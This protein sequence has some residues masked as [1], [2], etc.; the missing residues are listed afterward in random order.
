M[1]IPSGNAFSQE[2]NLNKAEVKGSTLFKN[3]SVEKIIGIPVI[4]N[5]ENLK[6]KIEELLIYYINEGYLNVKVDTEIDTSRESIILKFKEGKNYKLK[7]ILDENFKNN[8][9]T[10]FSNTAEM[11]TVIKEMLEFLN[12]N[13]YPY[14]SIVIDSILVNDHK[15][16]FFIKLD[17]G[18]EVRI[19]T[20]I[21][22]GV[23]NTNRDLIIKESGLKEGMLFN[24][25][26]YDKA[27]QYLNNSGYLEVKNIR[28][29]VGLSSGKYGS[30]LDLKEKKGNRFNGIIGYM[31]SRTVAE[32][33][34]FV[35]EFNL[36]LSNISGTGR[37]FGIRWNKP[38]KN[39]QEVRLAY[40]E[41]WIL[42]L[43]FNLNLHFN[44]AFYDS[45]Y[46]KRRIGITLNTR[47]GDKITGNV[48]IGSENVIPHEKNTTLIKYSGLAVSAEL[49]YNSMDYMLNP[50]DGILFGNSVEYVQRE[51]ENNSDNILD[52]R[53]FVNFEFARALFKN[54]VFYLKIF[55]SRISTSK[56]DIPLSQ[57]FLL[58]GASDLR[59]YREEQFR[60]PFMAYSNLEYRLVMDRNS[61][62][63]VFYD[64]GYFKHENKFTYKSGYGFGLRLQ[65]K[66]GIIGFDFALSPNL[67]FNESKIHFRLINEF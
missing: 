25:S 60:T 8:F 7:I 38:Q 48:S 51:N 39:N 1:F 21:V 11:E 20:I 27:Q 41:P 35:G 62:I 42:G 3:S 33:G 46:T 13:G 54:N 65:S 29:L 4:M 43:P 10:Q 12:R 9:K 56:G 28:K 47:I 16:D 14:A 45:L 36:F 2:F 15:A 44:Q 26:R 17:K 24:S 53:I 18:E 66:V 57:M 67:S 34:Y 40:K 31:P 22:R 58:G 6:E 23:E 49:T 52:K 5:Y 19:D 63:F 55:G 37:D 64:Q 59:G 30:I 61:R 50:T 32:R